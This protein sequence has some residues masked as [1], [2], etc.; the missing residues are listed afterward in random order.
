MPLSVEFYHPRYEK[1]A[2][3]TVIKPG[4]KPV[5]IPQIM[6]DGDKKIYVL[7]CD[8]TDFYTSIYCYKIPNNVKDD[9]I[10]LLNIDEMNP[11]SVVTIEKNYDYFISI[12]SEKKTERL[13]I[14][15]SQL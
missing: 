13:V 8:N 15:F 10:S 2:E 4:Q 14:K 6:P 9:D 5:V 3:L 1:W 12:K 7:K 11:D